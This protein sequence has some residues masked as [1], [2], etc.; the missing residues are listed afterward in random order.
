MTRAKRPPKPTPAAPVPANGLLARRSATRGGG[1]WR[2]AVILLAGALTYWNS[3]DGPFVFDDRGTILDNRSIET[4]WD[5]AVL[6]APHETPT[7]GRPVVN[8][9]FAINYALGQRDVRG[10]HLGNLAIHLA[11]ALLVFGCIKRTVESVDFAFASALIWTVHP[12]NTEVVNYLTQRT[13]SLMA[14]FYL[15]TMY[16]SIRAVREQRRARWQA[17]AVLACAL[18][19]ACKESM[20]TAPLMVLIYDRVFIFDSWANALRARGRFYAAL[21]ATWAVLAAVMATAPRGLSAGFSAHDA[22]PWT[23]LLNQTVMMT[24]YLWLAIWPRALT[25]Y[26]GWPMPLTLADVWPLG[27]MVDALLLMTAVAL[28]RQPRLGFLGVWFFLTLAPSSSI[29][30]IATEVGAERRMYLPLIAV[31]ILA[32]VAAVYLWK[33]LCRTWPALSPRTAAAAVCSIFA[34]TAPLAAQ[35]IARN[36]DYASSLRLAETTLEHWPTPAAHSMLGT[37]LAAAGRFAEAESHLR[38]AAPDFPPARYYLA[39]V[40]ARGGKTDEAIAAFRE[41]IRLQ[42]PELDQVYLA[43]GQLGDLLMKS[44]RVPEA[45]EQF[46]Q[47]LTARPGDTESKALLANALVRQQSYTEA[48]ELYRSVLTARP[49]DVRV[50]G[51]LGIALASSGRM[52]EAVPVFRR[53]AEIEPRNGHA[54]QN[55]ARALLASGNL[56]EAATH[57]QQ[58][59]LLT[60][61]DPGARALLAQIQSIQGK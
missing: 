17:L 8:I 3:L 23:Y 46:R 2:A 58:A 12:L 33:R 30:P 34:V 37:E 55:L 61:G 16:A 26:Y 32:V 59:L 5:R 48:I 10:Y 24:H 40:L 47:M 38:Q 51:G 54:H 1:R 57:A 4:L 18:G 21:A 11:C 53:A 22:A 27:L 52:D 25:L 49:D 6:F 60:P 36:R 44:Q 9:S 41:F 29:V 35:T 20:V 31:V 19:M 15:L 45:T 28:F 56:S 7:A 50:L 39:T 13:E 42:P 43:R 14:L